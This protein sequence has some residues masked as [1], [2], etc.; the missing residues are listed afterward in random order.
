VLTAVVT[1][2]LKMGPARIAGIYRMVRGWS[3]ACDVT[4]ALHTYPALVPRRRSDELG[5]KR[6]LT[7]TYGWRKA[8][9]KRVYR[10]HSIVLGSL[11]I[12]YW[13]TWA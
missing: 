5:N 7:V 12:T 10:L 3:T 4:V 9:V 1:P 6:E 2:D 11:L 8:R 13:Y